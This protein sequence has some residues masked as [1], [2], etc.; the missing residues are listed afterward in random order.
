MNNIIV[1]PMII[2][3]LTAI[4]LVFLRNSVKTQR[5]LSIIVKHRD[6]RRQRCHFKSNPAGW[7]FTTRFRWLVAALWYFVCGRFILHATRHDNF[8]CDGD[9]SHL[10]FFVHR[11]RV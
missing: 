6:N 5:V 10:R 3:L 8:H 1:L 7:D 2:P 4:I 9:S 11:E